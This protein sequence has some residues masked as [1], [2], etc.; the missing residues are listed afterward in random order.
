MILEGE[1]LIVELVKQDEAVPVGTVV[2]GGK[3]AVYI[4][5]IFKVGVIVNDFEATLEML[6]ARQVTIAFGPFPARD[7]QWANVIVKDNAGNYIQFFG[8]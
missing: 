3:G 1:G 5:G 4:H 7:G 8:K 2:P 6:K